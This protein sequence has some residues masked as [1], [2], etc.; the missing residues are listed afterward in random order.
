MI[1]QAAKY[2]SGAENRLKAA[3]IRK[4]LWGTPR[5]AT[6]QDSPVIKNTEVDL[7]LPESKPVPLWMAKEI[8]FDAHV[9]DYRVAKME[10]D[11]FAGQPVKAHIAKRAIDFQL[12]YDDI[13]GP[14]RKMNVVR[15]RQII[16]W[17][18]K[19]QV[20]PSMSYPELGRAVGGRDHTTCLYAVE[21]IEAERSGGEV[22]SKFMEKKAK[23]RWAA[24]RIRDRSKEVNSK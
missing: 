15:A 14:S 20:K 2:A 8:H 11:R 17:E 23:A 19:T 24:E 10:I 12:T 9:N 21:K 18:I 6:I 3:E 22:Y 1:V 16:I 4:R 7:G 13:V 5:K